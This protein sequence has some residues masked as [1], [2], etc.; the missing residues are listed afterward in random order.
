M[1]SLAPALRARLPGCPPPLEADRETRSERL[2]AAVISWISGLSQRAPV[3]IVLDDLHR[4]GAGLLRLLGLL[5]TD[6][7][8]KRVLV[9]ATAR[10]SPPDDTHASRPTP[11]ARSTGSTWSTTSTWPD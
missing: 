3:V 6:D 9:L 4:A 2:R 10:T 7:D 5:M 1:C 11:A 8:P